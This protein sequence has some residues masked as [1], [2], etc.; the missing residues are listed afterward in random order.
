[1][2]TTTI[3]CDRCGSIVHKPEFS[4]FFI[5][6]SINLDGIFKGVDLCPECEKIFGEWLDGVKDKKEG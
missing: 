4:G 2:R 6:R 3:V 1:M 5:R